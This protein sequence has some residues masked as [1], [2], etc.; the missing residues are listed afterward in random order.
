MT[1]ILNQLGQG[2]LPYFVLAVTQ[3]TLFLLLVLAVLHWLRSAPAGVKYTI[4][5]VGLVKLLLP[6]FLRLPVLAGPE[7][8]AGSLGTVLGLFAGTGLDAST[9]A[10][11]AAAPERLGIG[12]SLLLFWGAAALIILIASLTATARLARRLG[13]AQPLPP[14]VLPPDLKEK[15]VEVFLSDRI[16]LPLTLGLFPRRIFVPAIWHEWTPARRLLVLRHEQAHIERRDGLAKVLQIAARALYFFHPLVLL[17]DRRLNEYREM[18]C[19]DASLQDGKVS[20]LEVAKHLVEIADSVVPHSLQCESAIA[21]IRHKNE[22]LK[23]VRYQLKEGKMRSLSRLQGAALV[24]ALA[25]MVLPLSWYQGDAAP[26]N[27]AAVVAGTAGDPPAKSAEVQKKMQKRMQA[28]HTVSLVIKDDQTVVVD[29]QKAGLAKL[30]KILDAVAAGDP[31]GTV[32]ELDCAGDVPMGTLYKVQQILTERKLM[33]VKFARNDGAFLPLVLPP[34]N[35]MEKLKQMDPNDLAKI[36]LD[37]KGQVSWQGKT[38]PDGKLQKMLAARLA[39]N[40]QL[41]VVLRPAPQ[42]PYEDM[43]RV[44]ALVTA[45]DAQRVVILPVAEA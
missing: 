1:E 2:W 12:G 28:A 13:G 25:L 45:A 9:A 8:G 7:P 42:T 5:L 41:V 21:L 30:P 36:E 39:E 29:G 43:T 27:T 14:D 34:A 38:L 24:L 35:V 26:G 37:A 19:D 4:A 22:L 6:P 11:A 33:K 10:P 17:L 16:A 31:E 23:R 32:V 18:A 44:L 20:G 40:P 3:N 15:G